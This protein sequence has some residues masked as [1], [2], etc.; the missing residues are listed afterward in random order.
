MHRITSYSPSI[1]SVSLHGYYMLFDLLVSFNFF[2]VALFFKCHQFF[3]VYSDH[4]ME[5][6]L[7]LAKNEM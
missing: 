7:L 2:H 4:I 3:P 6:L 1:T 5:G